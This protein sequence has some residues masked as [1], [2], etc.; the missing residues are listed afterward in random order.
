MSPS[1]IFLL[2]E[3]TVYFQAWMR[4]KPQMRCVILTARASYFTTI[5]A[6]WSP[7]HNTSILIA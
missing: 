4:T 7:A 6:V 2:F 1:S 5:L 3:S